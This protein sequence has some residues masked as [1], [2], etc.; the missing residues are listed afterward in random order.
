L[1]ALGLLVNI[2]QVLKR[3]PGANAVAY[4]QHL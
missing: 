3:L 1:Y 2:R 4:H